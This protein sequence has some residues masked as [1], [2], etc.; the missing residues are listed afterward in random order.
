MK[1]MADWPQYANA[2]LETLL[3]AAW[4]L[5]AALQPAK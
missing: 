5:V 4:V 1:L 3:R 2:D